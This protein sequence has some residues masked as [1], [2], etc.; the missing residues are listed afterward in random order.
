MDVSSDAGHKG[1][2]VAL[3]SVMAAVRG[4]EIAFAFWTQAVSPPQVNVPA[5]SVMSSDTK[6]FSSA[7][8]LKLPLFTSTVKY[9]H[10][11]RW[12]PKSCFLRRGAAGHIQR[13]FNMQCAGLAV[14]AHA[15]IVVHTVGHVGVLLHL[16]NDDALADGVQ[17]TGRD[18]KAVPFMYR[19]G[20]QHVGQG[21]IFDALRKLLFGYLVV[22]AVVQ[23]RPRHAVQHIPHLGFAVLVFV[24]QRVVV[25][26]MHLN[27]QV[28]LGI[29]QLCQN[30]ELLELVAVG[31]KGDRGA[32]QH[33]LPAWCRRAD[34]W[35]RPG[36]RTVPTPLPAGQGRS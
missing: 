1:L 16:G 31:A 14:R 32:R 10:C 15:P 22:K 26:R 21:V 11:A 2:A 30:R 27:R 13:L 8:P 6:D 28:L 24:F 9:S 33:T 29:N 36:G 19:H 23:V 5:P 3:H 7:V 12:P 18:K 4:Q 25:G 35:L 20:V 17:R 34:S